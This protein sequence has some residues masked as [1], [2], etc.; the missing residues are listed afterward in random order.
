MYE[1]L[2]RRYAQALYDVCEKAGILEETL[3]DLNSI[4]ESMEQSEELMKIIE[5]P[6]IHRAEKK[7]IFKRLFEDQV[8]PELL[9]FLI[10]LI[11]KDRI[12]YLKE[13]YNQ[14]R[15]I[16]FERHNMLEA[17][18]K[19][20]I[21][22]IDEQREALKVKLKNKYK[23]DIILLEEIDESLLGGMVVKIG[24]D[25]I[26]GSIKRRMESMK[27]LMQ[28]RKDI[29]VD[30]SEKFKPLVAKVKTVQ[31]LN[32]EQKEQIIKKL[33]NYYNREF[34]IE[35]SIDKKILGGVYITVGDDVIDV[36]VKGKLIELRRNM[37]G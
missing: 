9:G 18:V 7:A 19:T 29:K 23:K 36:T 33:K 1:F 17:K 22:L 5:H 11:D 26:D 34:I 25:V 13:K 35:E 12:L 24:D 10:L 14:F 30:V 6:Q 20:T 4:V 21:P 15:L 2:D 32:E 16:Y 28:E 37:N 3:E 8:S 31:P 27:Q